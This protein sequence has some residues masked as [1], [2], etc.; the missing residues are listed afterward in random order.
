ME[1]ARL[2]G[3]FIQHYLGSR[4]KFDLHSPFVY[5][6]YSEILKD[7]KIYPEY[8]VMDDLRNRLLRDNR[9]ISRTDLGA[10]GSDIPWQKRTQPVN[11]ILRNNSVPPRFGKLLFRISRYF[12]PDVILELGTSVGVSAVCLAL[13]NI[14]G[15][16]ITIEGSPEIASVA[17]NNFETAGITN[18]EQHIGEFNS[19]LPEILLSCGQVDMV[20]I[21]GNHKKEATLGYFRQLLPYMGNDSLLILDDIYWSEGMTDAWKEIRKHPAVTVTIDLFRMGLVFF[22]KELSKEDFLIRF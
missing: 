13:G 16:V 21:D 22:R 7:K 4:S 14:T 6:L 19:Q 1:T 8:E 17:V 12:K 2:I 15:K 9:F 10:R 20:F 18:V 5:H 11:R 3:R